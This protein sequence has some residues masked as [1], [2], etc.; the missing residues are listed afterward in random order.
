MNATWTGYQLITDRHTIDIP[1]VIRSKQIY[2]EWQNIAPWD[3][4]ERVD[5]STVDIQLF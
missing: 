4:I 5:I 1:G 2:G 3:S